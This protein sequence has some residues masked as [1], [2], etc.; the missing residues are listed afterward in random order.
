MF[1]IQ[2]ANSTSH[3]GDWTVLLSCAS[4]MLCADVMS[5]SDDINVCAN[6]VDLF[7]LGCERTRLQADPACM[8]L[9]HGAD[10]LPA[11]LPLQGPPLWPS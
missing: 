8:V 5:T 6:A 11:H 10:L 3:T 4:A 2:Q 7:L 9:M 1:E